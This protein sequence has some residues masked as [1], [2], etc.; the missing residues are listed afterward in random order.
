MGT[1]RIKS[2]L[3][4][5]LGS[6]ASRGSDYGGYYLFGYIVESLG[7]L[8]VDL[9]EPILEAGSPD[10]QVTSLARSKFDEQLRKSHLNRSSLSGATLTIRRGEP[11]DCN[12][13]GV[14]LPPLQGWVVTFETSARM[15]SGR[16][17]SDSETVCIASQEAMVAAHERRKL[18]S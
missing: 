6:Y 9:L 1:R 3:R 7:V 17:Y 15:A 13:Y 11:Q 2:V 10:A 8:T 5:F 16:T 4:G 12:A 18:S 14:W